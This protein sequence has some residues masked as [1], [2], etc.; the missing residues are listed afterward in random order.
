L[1]PPATEA[2]P[3]WLSTLLSEAFPFVVPKAE[4]VD[5]LLLRPFHPS[6]NRGLAEVLDPEASLT[7]KWFHTW[8]SKDSARGT[9]PSEVFSPSPMIP[10][11]N[12]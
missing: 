3:S 9:S 1:F 7:S 5:S 12:Q 6:P 4:Q 11:N 8:D 2:I 10:K